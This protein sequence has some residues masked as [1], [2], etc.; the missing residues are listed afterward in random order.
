MTTLRTAFFVLRFA[1]QVSKRSTALSFLEILMI[2]VDAAAPLAFALIIGG[3]AGQAMWPLVAGL[4]L[5][6]VSF[7]LGES[8]I[9]VA[10]SHRVRLIESVGNAADA[11]VISAV[12]LAPSLDAV[13]RRD[14]ADA[15]EVARSR[16]RAMGF[17]FNGIVTGLVQ[18]VIPVTSIGVALFLDPRLALLAVAGVPTI[19]IVTQVMK[20]QDQADTET[21]EVAARTRAWTSV[22]S[23]PI[24]R[25]ERRLY[26]C[27][28]WQQRTLLR[29]LHQWRAPHVRA[30]GKESVLTMVGDL[31][32]IA[33][34]AAVLVWIS[35]DV[36]GGTVGPDVLVGG[37]AVAL[38]LQSAADGF[39]GAFTSFGASLRAARSLRHVMVELGEE[40]AATITTAPVDASASGLSFHNVTYTY[41]GGDQP[42]LRDVT[43]EIPGGSVVALV[44]ENGCGKSTFTQMALGLRAPQAGEVVGA[45]RRTQR[46]PGWYDG[47]SVVPQHVARLE[48]SLRDAVGASA[49][50]RGKSV[51]DQAV[52]RALA[53]SFGD[54]AQA[55]FPDGVS[56]Q[57]G[58]QWSGGVGLSSGQWQKVALARGFA[59]PA[60]RVVALDEPTSALDPHSYDAALTACFAKAH[61][62]T[63]AG[64]VA[65]VVTHRLAFARRAD[66]ILVLDGGRIV[67]QGTHEELMASGGQYARDFS[68][69]QSGFATSH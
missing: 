8:L 26:G 29:Y 16:A 68:L 30:A 17:A 61:D 7:A 54:Q 38:G 21:R 42:A 14:V 10:V 33:C 41:E 67:E 34:A 3:V 45:P 20:A 22:W 2:G 49:V 31:F 65:I 40:Q 27:G 64:G 52:G 13:E 48:F 51:D 11:R 60:T 50:A 47:V 66:I 15:V 55:V 9:M 28:G 56:T 24:A 35:R 39:R 59:T 37:L 4:A 6:V 23:D 1:W 19:M 36:V 44:G 5:L 57:L 53:A 32:Y 63:A 62:V 46:E 58:D 25:Q 18:L 12:T 43:C 69:Q